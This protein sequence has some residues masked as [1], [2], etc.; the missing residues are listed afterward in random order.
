M[1]IFGPFLVD[2][3]RIFLDDLSIFGGQAEHLKHLR[4]CFAKCWEVLFS[5]NS[6]KCAFMVCSGWLL[7][8]VILEAGI[9]VDLDKIAAIMKAPPPQTQKQCLGFLGQVHWHSR[10][11]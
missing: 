4:L 2:F 1:E 8:H 11:L 6:N 5:L 7:G 10:H 9:S 3:M